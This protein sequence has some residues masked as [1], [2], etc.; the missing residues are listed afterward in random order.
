MVQLSVILIDMSIPHKAINVGVHV[1]NHMYAIHF[2][3]D[4]V[5]M[6]CHFDSSITVID[7]TQRKLGGAIVDSSSSGL[8]PVE[9][10]CGCEEAI[11]AFC[12]YF[13]CRLS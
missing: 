10:S 3:Y 9:I 8:V 6:A 7:D 1:E 2:R 13:H 5:G 11:L 4:R 12:T